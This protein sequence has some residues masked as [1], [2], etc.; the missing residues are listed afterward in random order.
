MQ[1]LQFQSI[2]VIV[3]QGS[4]RPGK[5]EKPGKL[6]ELAS[7]SGKSGKIWKTQGLLFE[8]NNFDF[9]QILIGGETC[10]LLTL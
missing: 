3:S 5:P 8:A 7:I 2:Q 10:L 6:K 4:D 9:F 1:M